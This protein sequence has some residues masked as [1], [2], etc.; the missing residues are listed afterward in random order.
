MTRKDQATRIAEFR[1]RKARLT[2]DRINL[3][4]GAGG[5]SSA[6]LV[7][8]VFV[9]AFANDALNAL[10]D[11][12]RVALPDGQSLAMSTDSFV[13][14]PLRFPGGSIGHLAVHG[15]INDVA[16]L[17]ARPTHLSV[18]C[19]IE[20]GFLVAELREIVDDMAG[21]ARD[22]DVT[23]VAGDTKVVGKGAAD[24]MYISTAAVGLIPSNRQ[25]GAAY[26]QP[27]DAIILSGNLGDHGIAVLLARDE[28][29]I[30]ADVRSDTAPIHH[31][32]EALYT[33]GISPKWIRDPTRGGLG[34]VCNELAQSIDHTVV[35]EETA[36]PV[37]STVNAVCDLLGI[38][39][40]YVACEGRFVAVVRKEDAHAA[41]ATLRANGNENA[42]II[43]HIG[44]DS[45][46]TVQL[47][48]AFGGTRMVDMLV[49]DPLP[50]IC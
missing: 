9:R 22:A 41:V 26:V 2:D 43:G 27:G 21:A 17:G 49:G 39:P 19:I 40:I 16:C 5:K 4:H 37:S 50:R 18:A 35:L 31:S 42:C 8:D 28:L 36:L 25:I 47:S 20:E 10:E 15:S 33:A 38:D 30:E 46:A 23:I 6:L 12:G 34:T 45:S 24:G 11:A 1:K 13:V 3:A 48:T 44:Q 32:I 29:G 7:E 14:Q